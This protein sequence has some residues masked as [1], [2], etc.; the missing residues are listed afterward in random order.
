MISK[1]SFIVLVAVMSFSWIV[2]NDAPLEALLA[3][4]IAAIVAMRFL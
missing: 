3:T 2:N 1:L 4:V